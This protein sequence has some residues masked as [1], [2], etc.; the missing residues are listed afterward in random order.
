MRAIKVHET[1][2]PERLR[3]EDIPEPTPGPGEVLVDVE[4]IGVN[5]IEIYQ[6]EGMYPMQR[7]F[8]PG[9][10]A[11]GTVRALGQ[12]VTDLAVGDRIVSQRMK[13]AYAERAVVQADLAV[14]IPD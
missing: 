1:G 4:A 12:G 8:P 10:E 6:R 13:G 2:G 3:V 5:F 7:R 11:A 14:R 9:A